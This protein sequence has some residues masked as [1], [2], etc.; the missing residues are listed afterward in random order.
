MHP[1]AAQYFREAGLIKPESKAEPARE[2]ARARS[3]KS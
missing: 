3:R 1:G 2:P